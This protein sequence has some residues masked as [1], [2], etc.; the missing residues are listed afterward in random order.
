MI[1]PEKF[2]LSR[3]TQVTNLNFLR[4]VIGEDYSPDR[5]RNNV[6]MNFDEFSGARS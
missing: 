2:Q 4:E 1:K 3:Y 5:P 6:S